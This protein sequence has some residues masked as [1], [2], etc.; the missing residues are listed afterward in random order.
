MA[1]HGDTAAHATLGASAG[2]GAGA[3]IVNNR[4]V[5]PGTPLDDGDYV[6]LSQEPLEI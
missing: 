1:N 3:V 2:A 5:P 4:P 6:V